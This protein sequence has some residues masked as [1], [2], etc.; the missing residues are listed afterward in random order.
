MI[1]NYYFDMDGVLAQYEREAYTG[2]KPLWLQPNK[3]YFLN[4]KP[5]M[6]ALSVIDLL[7]SYIRTGRQGLSP[8]SQIYIVSSISNKNGAIFNEQFHDKLKWIAEK[9]PY[10]PVENFYI[11]VS[12]KRDIC[13]MVNN[14][15]IS[16]N[17]GPFF[18]C[19]FIV[20]LSSTYCIQQIFKIKI[21]KG[22]NAY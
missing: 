5:D 18:Y 13:E 15:H 19:I 11:S 10:F 4:V 2:D 1:K 16:F 6:R 17:C 3:H 20:C 14:R 12:S 7:W 9:I 8:D 22:C 21:I